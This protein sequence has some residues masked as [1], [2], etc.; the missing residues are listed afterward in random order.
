MFK[1]VRNKCQIVFFFFCFIGK[2]I[3]SQKLSLT[4]RLLFMRFKLKMHKSKMV[5]YVFVNLVMFVLFQFV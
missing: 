3:S 4:S 2:L 1:N 5:M